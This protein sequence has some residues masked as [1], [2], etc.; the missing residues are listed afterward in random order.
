MRTTVMRGGFTGAGAA[1]AGA[2]L[3]TSGGR[4]T[5]TIPTMSPMM[6]GTPPG[7]PFGTPP[8]TPPG[9]A[10]T[11]PMVSGGSIIMAAIAGTL[12]NAGSVRAWVDSG[13]TAPRR[14]TG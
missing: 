2:R 8:G 13:A 7:T 5:G 6:R 4:T 10:P 9:T 11:L 3:T 1:V 14:G 12:A